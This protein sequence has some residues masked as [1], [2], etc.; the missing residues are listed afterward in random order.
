[1]TPALMP[2]NGLHLHSAPRRARTQVN[3]LDAWLAPSTLK[4]F[5]SSPSFLSKFGRPSPCESSRFRRGH[6]SSSSCAPRA[7]VPGSSRSAAPRCA[8]VNDS[9]PANSFHERAYPP[10]CPCLITWRCWRS[11]KGAPTVYQLRLVTKSTNLKKLNC[12]KG[13]ENFR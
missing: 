5:A 1:M 4:D 10:T 6:S 2:E 13:S 9:A 8:P 3:R 7:P 12:N 11:N